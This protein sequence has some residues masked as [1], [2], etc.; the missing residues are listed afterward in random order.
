MHGGRA[1]LE[2]NR[3]PFFSLIFIASPM[4]HRPGQ[5]RSIQSSQSVSV[6]CFERSSVVY[7]RCTVDIL[8]SYYSPS[9]RIYIFEIF[10]DEGCCRMP[11]TASCWKSKQRNKTGTLFILTKNGFLCCFS[12]SVSPGTPLSHSLSRTRAMHYE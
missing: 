1:C 7:G 3:Y 5:Y 12:V 2:V 11:E 10:C 6:C 8:Q 9:R 4:A